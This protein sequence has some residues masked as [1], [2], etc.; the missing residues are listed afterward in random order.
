[1]VV[2][3]VIKILVD[4]FINGSWAFIGGM[5]WV[6]IF[7]SIMGFKPL[8]TSDNLLLV[9]FVSCFLLGLWFIPLG[10]VDELAKRYWGRKND[11]KR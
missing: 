4:S 2:V 8:A 6:G 10:I 7:I 5:F 11:A 3:L 9:L 1:M